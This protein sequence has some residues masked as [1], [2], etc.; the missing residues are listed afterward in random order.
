MLEPIKIQGKLSKLD[1]SSA[2]EIVMGN[3]EVS[4]SRG[5]LKKES[6]LNS[7]KNKALRKKST[8]ISQIIQ[9]HSADKPSVKA[10]PLAK[11]RPPSLITNMKSKVKE[12]SEDI[13][14]P[15]LFE[16][17]KEEVKIKVVE[18]KKRIFGIL[19]KFGKTKAKS[20]TSNMTISLSK[21][22]HAM[23]RDNATLSVKPPNLNV[24][25]KKRGDSYHFLWKYQSRGPH[26]N[27][28]TFTQR[29]KTLMFASKLFE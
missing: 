15:F 25:S 21:D 26:L 12:T 5:I 3:G 27:H 8:K 2:D 13:P 17:S 18:S 20:Q 23:L 6:T 4:P 14:S 7:P 10:G 29:F 9:I 1:F 11:R 16:K 28:M 22:Q 24:T 19:S